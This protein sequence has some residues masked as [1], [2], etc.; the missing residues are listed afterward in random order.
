M[1]NEDQRREMLN[2]W[3]A[4]LKAIPGAAKA[5]TEV[6]GELGH[7]GAA[8]VRIGTAKAEQKVQAIK[9]DTQMATEVSEALTRAAIQHIE[10][11]ADSLGPRALAY[12]ARRFV[13]QQ[14]NREAVAFEALEHLRLSPPREQ[15][16]GEPSE[17]WLHVF[18]KLAENASSEKLR[19]HFAHVLESEI[20]KP[21]SISFVTLQMTSLLD[22]QL[23]K[24]I[25]RMRPYILDGVNIPLI[26]KMTR[27]D[28]YSDLVALA[29]VG[30]V[31]I[32][33]HTFTVDD[34]DEGAPVE[35]ALDQLVVR[36]PAIEIAPGVRRTP[37]VTVPS[38]I[39]SQAGQE[40]LST[41]PAV[42][43]SPEAAQMLCD[44]LR[45]HGY[46]MAEIVPIAG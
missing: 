15:P 16:K 26:G 12:G 45:T 31:H 4:L 6:V 30:F 22:D 46:P 20:R 24:K 36:V 8:L 42:L 41:L 19:A 7:A 29:G 33:D 27:G 37:K 21:G 32:A 34:T 11:N 10:Q 39:V 40:L 38:I 18:S 28:Y 14:Q 1:P 44:W 43:G 13:K 3:L 35:F 25:E 5:L 23:A 2:E 9:N 17:D